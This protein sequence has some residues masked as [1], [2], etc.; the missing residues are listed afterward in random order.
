[1][2]TQI[3]DGRSYAVRSAA[4]PSIEHLIPQ[5][6]FII[7]N[8]TLPD[9]CFMTSVGNGHVGTVVDSD[10]I[11][12]NG[13]YNGRGGHSHRARIPSMVSCIIDRFEPRFNVEP[14][15]LYTLN[16]MNGMYLE[17]IYGDD[18][19]LEKKVYAHR[20]KTHL[21]V[22]EIDV[23]RIHKENQTALKVFLKN[24]KGKK[25]Y[26]IRFDRRSNRRKYMRGTTYTSETLTS[27]RQSIHIYYD[28]LLSSLVV[29]PV[30]STEKA[31]RIKW[32]FYASFAQDRRD[33]RRS[34]A[35]AIIHS[36]TDKLLQSHVAAWHALWTRSA[37]ILEGNLPLARAVSGAM[38]YILSSIQLEY[39]P[40]DPFIGL[41]PS[42]LAHGDTSEDYLGHVFWDQDTWMYPGVL[43]MFPDLGKLL[44][45]TRLRTLAA[46]KENAKLNGNIGAQFPWEIAYTGHEVCPGEVYA[47]NEIHISGDISFAFRQY[48]CMTKDVDF[49]VEEG[50]REL[51]TAISRFW[52]GRVSYDQNKRKFEI[53]SVMPPDEMRQSIHNSVYTNYVASL[54]LRADEDISRSLQINSTGDPNWLKIADDLVILFDED[55]QFHPEFEGYRRGYPIK[56][57]DVILLGF[58]LMMDMPEHVRRNDLTFYDAVTDPEGP[59]MTWTM[60]AIGWLELAEYDKAHTLLMKNMKHVQQPFQVWSEVIGGQGGVNFITGMGGLLQSM[61]FGYG[62]FRIRQDHLEFNP[63]L[64]DQVTRLTLTGISY[65]GGVFT[66]CIQEDG[67]DIT[68]T[69]TQDHFQLFNVITL[70]TGREDIL[71]CDRP[72]R[73]GLEKAKIIRL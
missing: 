39:D 14:R 9:A 44:L 15:R 72:H 12:M 57:A 32:L 7:S 68:L 13:F 27:G 28:P 20:Q 43:M 46:A 65:Q 48:M 55:E 71:H 1:M 38:Y 29:P 10:T 35:L 18:F 62:G 42:D 47:K 30:P 59:A 58:P 56:Q 40:S 16:M 5:D 70:S 52:D 53:L 36:L 17:T 67:L 23:I 69:S 60:S 49:Y 24:N 3:H 33:A 2:Y 31:Q 64:P 19:I 34:Y 41:S 25:S 37:I 8:E 45:R 6:A 26:D 63:S 61:I 22:T 50:G 51:V 11:L 21:L 73:I 66:F 4:L 54:A